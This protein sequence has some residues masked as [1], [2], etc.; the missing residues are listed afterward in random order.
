MYI[1]TYLYTHTACHGGLGRPADPGVRASPHQADPQ[2]IIYMH[3]LTIYLSLY[4]YIYIYIYREREIYSYV[5]IYI[6]IYMA[7]GP[8]H[9]KLTLRQ[10]AILIDIISQSLLAVVVVVVIIKLIIIST[11]LIMTTIAMTITTILLI[12]L[13]VKMI[14]DPQAQEHRRAARHAEVHVRDEDGRPAADRH[15]PGPHMYIYI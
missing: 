12:I 2:A 5:Y 6:Y 15:L 4:V 7:C 14:A 3:I 13:I 1:Y 11:I 10:S 9:I 8:P